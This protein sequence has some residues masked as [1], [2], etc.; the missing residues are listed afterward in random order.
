MQKSYKEIAIKNIPEETNIINHI[1]NDDKIQK[2]SL[3]NVIEPEEDD[4]VLQNISLFIPRVFDNITKE[5]IKEVFENKMYLGKISKIDI[6]KVDNKNYNRVFIHFEY[7][8]ETEQ[9]I[10]IQTTLL[11]EKKEN[12]KI[13]YD[14]LWYWLVVVNK[15]F[16]PRPNIIL[17]YEDYYNMKQIQDILE[18]DEVYSIDE[19]INKL[20]NELDEIYCEE[21]FINNNNPSSCY[22]IYDY[23]DEYCECYDEETQLQMDDLIN[24]HFLHDDDNEE[25]YEKKT[26]FVHKDYVEILENRIV[27]LQNLHNMNMYNL[28]ISH[29]NYNILLNSYN[30][31]KTCC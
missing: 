13:Y 2:Y 29:Q 6:V 26:E 11:K 4:I 30:H 27:Q 17:T 16:E 18:V 22:D 7:W 3:V 1:K 24:N 12:T 21:N 14:K 15:A 19:E 31:L 10:R 5:M 23:N 28:F 20:E 25:E 9:S 8:F